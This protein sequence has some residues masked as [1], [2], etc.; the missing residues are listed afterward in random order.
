MHTFEDSSDSIFKFLEDITKTIVSSK[1]CLP[2]VNDKTKNSDEAIMNDYLRIKVAREYK[3][4][5]IDLDLDT[6]YASASLSYLGNF[7]RNSVFTCVSCQKIA[8][9]YLY[10]STG[11]FMKNP[12]LYDYCDAFFNDLIANLDDEIGRTKRTLLITTLIPKCLI[13]HLAKRS[14]SNSAMQFDIVYVNPTIYGS[15]HEWVHANFSAMFTKSISQ[16]SHLYFIPI[17][18]LESKSKRQNNVNRLAFCADTVVSSKLYPTSEASISKDDASATISP[19]MDSST[20]FD[21]STDDGN[22]TDYDYGFI[23]DSELQRVM[24]E[25]RVLRNIFFITLAVGLLVNG[26]LLA[27]NLLRSN[28]KYKEFWAK[29]GYELKEPPE[30]PEED[31]EETERKKAEAKPLITEEEMND[32]DLLIKSAWHIDKKKIKIDQSVEVAGNERV[33]IYKGIVR[34]G[35]FSTKHARRAIPLLS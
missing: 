15:T 8:D 9:N 32:F 14:K 26:V 3:D 34:V 5:T 29:C 24:G 2:T 30:E 27:H 13:E 25:V 21:N 6:E 31:E 23:D 11:S 28:E 20:E 17:N 19:D 18:K 22:S 35:S 1:N 12:P 33:V 16:Q 4:P 7:T 10:Q